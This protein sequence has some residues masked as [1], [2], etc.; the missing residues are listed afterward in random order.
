MVVVDDRSPHSNHP[1]VHLAR[2]TDFSDEWRAYSSLSFLGYQ[3]QTVNHSQNFVDPGTGAHTNSVEG[4]WS[5]IKR[6]MRRQGVM[7]TS[8][9]LFATYLL[10]SLWR[11]RFHGQDL[12]EKLLECIAEQYPL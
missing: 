12:F 6:Q 4:Y 11:K 10:E 2:H 9:D 7:N 8:N 5:C 3:H 1:E